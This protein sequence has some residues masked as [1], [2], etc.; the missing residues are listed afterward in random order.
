MA[1]LIPKR[2]GDRSPDRSGAAFD[3]PLATA[4]ELLRG[5]SITLDQI[6][7][8]ARLDSIAE[9]AFRVSCDSPADWLRALLAR[10]DPT[11]RFAEALDQ[12]QGEVAEDLL[13]S[14]IRAVLA[15]AQTQR[16]WLAL[17]ALEAERYQGGTLNALVGAL[18]PIANAL[19]A[20]LKATNALRPIP[21]WLIARALS[22]LLIGFV[23]SESALPAG[24][25]WAARLMPARMWADGLT[26]ILLYGILEDKS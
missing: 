17:A 18:L 19:L 25:Q 6:A 21:D 4:I 20:R 1:P 13:R 26:D 7:Q 5:D 22:S 9:A 16:D 11:A 10:H 8:A 2:S 12:A 3:L 24:L 14:S 15:T 23:A